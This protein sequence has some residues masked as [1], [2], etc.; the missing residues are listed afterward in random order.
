MRAGWLEEQG[1]S[2]DR[3]WKPTAGKQEVEEGIL[4]KGTEHRSCQGHQ[5]TLGGAGDN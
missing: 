4:A 5:L 1:R 2:E 3:G